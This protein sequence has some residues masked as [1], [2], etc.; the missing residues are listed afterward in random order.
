MKVISYADT[1]EALDNFGI[2]NS[3]ERIVGTS[4]GAMNVLMYS[5]DYT[6]KE[7]RQINLITNFSRYNPKSIRNTSD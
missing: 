1:F 2:S 7:N 4:S 5:L 6:G 3:I